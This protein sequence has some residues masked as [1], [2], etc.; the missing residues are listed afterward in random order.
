MSANT[1]PARDLIRLAVDLLNGLGIEQ[2]RSATVARILVEA[3][4]MGHTTHGLRLL[5]AYLRELETGRMKAQ[6]D[7]EIVSDQGAAV[8]W[9]GNYLP[10]MWLTATAIEEAIERAEK[11]P[12]VTYVI[13]RSHHIGCLAAYMPMITDRKYLGILSASDPSAQLV[14]PFGGR[15]PLFTPNPIAAGI[16]A[17]S[18]GPVI[19][20]ISSSTTAAGVVNRHQKSGTRLP[21]QWL[22]DVDGN[23]TDDPSTFGGDRSSSILPLGGLDVGYKGYALALLIEAMTSALSGHGRADH[24]T[25]WGTSVFLQI[26]NPAAFAGTA[27]FE[28]ETSWLAEACR[29]AAPR[30]GGSQVRVPGDRALALKAEQLKSGVHVDAEVMEALDSWRKKLRQ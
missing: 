26:I 5:P 3:D 21:G 27:A 24:P 22:L 29:A 2:S 6:G 4:L 17:G 25:T 15:T 11:Y 19:I 30:P 16:P 7:P 9:D 23:P 20:D 14:A 13:R 12:V 28:R 1:Y 10:G 18:D 8:V